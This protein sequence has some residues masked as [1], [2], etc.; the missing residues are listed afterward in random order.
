V[1]AAVR[2][3]LD[4]VPVQGADHN[5]LVLLDGDELVDA[6]VRLADQVSGSAGPRAG[7]G[8]S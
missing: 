3:P 8:R 4:E 5:D 2:G 1:A 6:V 7:G